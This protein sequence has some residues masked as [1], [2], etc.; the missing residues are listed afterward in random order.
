MERLLHAVQELSLA[1]SLPEIQR[2]V[3]HAAREVV[4]CDGTT[5]VLREGDTCYYADEYAIAPLWKGSRFALA[6]CVS[7]WVMLNGAAAV[8]PN[9]YGDDRVPHAAYR[10]TFVKSLVMVPIRR[11]RPVGAIGTYWATERSATAREVALLQALADSTSIAM[12]N[13]QL[14]A[15]LERRV[16]DRTAALEKANDEIR[17]L[18][19]TDDLTGLN[20][21]RGFYLLAESALRAARRNNHPC[22]LAYIDVNGL[23]KVNDVLGHDAGNSLI[24]DVAEVLRTTLGESDILGRIGGDEFCALIMEPGT[25]PAWLKDRL[26][27]AFRIFNESA[28]RPYAMSASVGLA[29]TETGGYSLDA[30]LTRADELMYVEKRT[31]PDTRTAD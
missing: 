10:P 7:G 6:T 11:M 1:R 25:D 16:R 30:L 4:G 23:K 19:A 3:R 2:I 5:F 14:Y 18:S 21:R 24:S 9:I 13:I 8:I 17:Q 22:L 26:S 27:E 28:T 29:S 20:N 15:E 31:I 12:E